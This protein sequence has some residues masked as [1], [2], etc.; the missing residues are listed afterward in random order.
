MEEK[1]LKGWRDAKINMKKQNEIKDK[2]K[3][4]IDKFKEGKGISKEQLIVLFLTGVLLMVIAWPTKREEKGTKLEAE[5]T[6]IERT[7][8]G[9]PGNRDLE[10]YVKREEEKLERLLESVAGVGKVR[11]MITVHSSEKLVVEKDR[12][13]EKKQT[14]EEDSGGGKREIWETKN[15]EK[16]V[17]E[18]PL[19]VQRLLPEIKGIAIVA[20][21]AEKNDVKDTL[22]E[23]VVTLYGLET[24]QVRVAGMKRT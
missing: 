5:N 8:E 3:E 18:E 15:E 6:K 20:Q 16:T 12:D 13:Y 10:E 17:Y 23:L 24:F 2:A 4:L 21:G 22:T 9:H 1:C 7:G 11:V 14:K 19:V